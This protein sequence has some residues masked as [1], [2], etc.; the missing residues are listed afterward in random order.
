MFGRTLKVSAAIGGVAALLLAIPSVEAAEKGNLTISIKKIKNSNG[1]I[2]VCL[3]N[4]KSSFPGCTAD[5]P[6]VKT[7]NA[8]AKKGSMSISV[9]Q[10]PVGTYAIS[11]AHDQNNDGKIEK[12]LLFGYPTEGAGMSN[13]P[14]PP[15]GPPKY[16]TAKFQLTK[17]TK[18]VDV[19][20]HYP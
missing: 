15:F 1:R 17:G 8:K 10:M 19:V 16:D 6:G 7:F 2:L 14:K 11:A 20:M 5:G 13:Y 3:F 9:K 12:H 18:K 4:K